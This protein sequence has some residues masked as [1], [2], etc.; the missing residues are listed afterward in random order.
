MGLS[1][2]PTFP[3]EGSSVPARDLARGSA[4][5]A[6]AIQGR[7]ASFSTGTVLA[8]VVVSWAINAGDWGPS[9]SPCLVA[10]CLGSLVATVALAIGWSTEPDE[11]ERWAVRASAAA[12]ISALPLL[13][14]S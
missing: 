1:Y 12:L 14:Q 4:E 10:V 9:Q 7:L 8:A 5:L 2:L 13:P 6:L 11:I 3:F